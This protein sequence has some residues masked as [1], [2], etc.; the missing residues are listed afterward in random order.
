[1]SF[2]FGLFSLTYKGA[3]VLV[4]S[5]LQHFLIIHY[6]RLSLP[7]SILE[8]ADKTYGARSGVPQIGESCIDR[9]QRMA[10]CIDNEAEFRSR[11]LNNIKKQFHSVQSKI[12]K[13]LA[14]KGEFNH[15]DQLAIRDKF[16]NLC[17]VVQIVLDNS[18]INI[19]KN[20]SVHVT[21]PPLFHRHPT[22]IK[23]P[24]ISL[25]TFSGNVTE[26][27]VFYDLFKSLVHDYE[28]L[29]DV[30]RFRYLLLSLRDEPLNLIKSFPVTDSNYQNVNKSLR[31]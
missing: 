25:P 14:K 22:K 5:G 13:H 7:A 8:T 12:E 4:N 26:R 2:A 6:L 27:N 30:Q 19:R 15:E 29:S 16:D 9:I 17:Y 20:S 11:E 10:D 31:Q 23:L 18:K 3:R 21:T 24:T 28:E 1:M